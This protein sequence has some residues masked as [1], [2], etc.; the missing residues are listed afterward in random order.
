MPDLT[1]FE[2]PDQKIPLER[3]PGDGLIVDIGGGGEGLV[4]RIEG[5]RVCAIDKK[6]DEIREAMIHNPPS[7]WFVGDGAHLSFKDDVF[8]V[9]TLWFSLGY[10]KDW[11][12]KRAVLLDA[13][14]VLKEGAIISIKATKIVCEEERLVFRV[15]Y[16]LP[17]GTLSRTGYGLKGQ[18]N[19]T[20]QTVMTC[21]QEIGF[22]V[23]EYHDYDHWFTIE[24]AKS[25]KSGPIF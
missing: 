14:R 12:I 10:M 1:I 11:H 6:M 2:P 19:Q 8:D 16:S 25:L 24:G 15:D 9:V 20:L 21:L 13:Y 17:D 7:N 5:T 4:S 3:I 22:E 23:T 18:Q